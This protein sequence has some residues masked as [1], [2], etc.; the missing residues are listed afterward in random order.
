MI[1]G[2]VCLAC[3]WDLIASITGTTLTVSIPHWMASTASGVLVGMGA[4]KTY[5]VSE[6][7]RSYAQSK[8]LKVPQ[9][10]VPGGPNDASVKPVLPAASRPQAPT[11]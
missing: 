2:Y 7:L 10:W 4:Q 11:T 1:R 6:G 3:S 8:G 9:S 5:D